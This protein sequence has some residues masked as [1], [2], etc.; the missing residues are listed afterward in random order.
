MKIPDAALLW[1]LSL[2][3][4][5][6]LGGPQLKTHVKPNAG[7]ERTAKIAVVP[8]KMGRADDLVLPDAVATELLGLGLHVVERSTLSQLVNDPTYRQQLQER[9]RTG[10]AGAMEPLLWAYAYGKPKE[11]LEVSYKLEVLTDAELAQL[12]HLV[13][14]VT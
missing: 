9:L 13:Q 3:M 12:E 1:V 11:S 10:E 6:C 5:S 2:V 14:R 8:A 7:I 4:V